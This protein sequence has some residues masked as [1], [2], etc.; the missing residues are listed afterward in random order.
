MA[1]SQPH[2]AEHVNAPTTS[3]QAL[4]ELTDIALPLNKAFSALSDKWVSKPVNRTRILA[5]TV[6]Q[7]RR[8][9]SRMLVLVG[10]SSAGKTRACWEAV[11][12][13]AERGRWLWHP[14]DPTRAEAALEDLHVSARARWCG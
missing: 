14:F 3:P 6:R 2:P 13:L 9:C 7:A 10:E 12:P 8:G 11:Q 4:P 1:P 5:E